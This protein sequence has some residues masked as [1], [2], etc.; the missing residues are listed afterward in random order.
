MSAYTFNDL[1]GFGWNKNLNIV[2]CNSSDD[3]SSAKPTDDPDSSSSYTPSPA[4]APTVFKNDYSGAVPVLDTMSAVEDRRDNDSPAPV[5]NSPAPVSNSNFGNGFKVL[6]IPNFTVKSGDTLSQIAKDNNTTVEAIAEANN[7]SDPNKIQTGQNLSMPG[8]NTTTNTSPATGSQNTTR[9]DIANSITKNDGKTYTDGKLL[10]DS[11][12]S[13]VT[14]TTDWQELANMLTPSDGTSYD[15]GQLVV[16]NDNTIRMEIANSITKDDGMTYTDGQLLNESDGSLVTDNTPYQDLTNWVTLTD[17]KMYE[18]GQ[19]TD[20]IIPFGED[21]TEKDEI[22]PDPLNDTIFEPNE[23]HPTD[24]DDDNDDDI[25]PDPDPVIVPDPDPVIVPD[26]DPVTDTDTETDYSDLAD[27]IAAITNPLRTSGT[28][29]T[30]GTNGTDGADG[31]TA[32][33]D[34]SKYITE[35]QLAAYIK[36]LD[37]GSN[38]YDPAAFMNMFGFAMNSAQNNLVKTADTTS[39]GAYVRRAVKDRDTGEIRYV[40]VP[41]GQ[42]AINGNDGVSWLRDRRPSNST[43]VDEFRFGRR[44]G[45]ASMV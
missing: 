41:I 16:G 3:V 13:L 38:A 42:G 25:V 22:I 28:P 20:G 1:C 35:E 10:N 43:I 33:P 7:I 32:L 27:V 14:E 17:G 40:N 37:L 6:K 44:N 21:P 18:G 30:D 2:H 15:D 5:S 29:G 39:S 4:P 8:G 36:N 24:G 19:L 26:P 45:F 9:M 31:V 34:L 12:G 11:D 23:P